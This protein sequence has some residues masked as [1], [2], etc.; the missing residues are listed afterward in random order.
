MICNIQSSMKDKKNK[1]IDGKKDLEK[2]ECILENEEKQNKRI[3]KL[4]YSVYRNQLVMQTI[5]R[6]ISSY[7][8][9]NILE[10]VSNEMTIYSRN[11]PCIDLK[12][13]GGKKIHE[14][15][16]EDCHGQIFAQ[17]NGI[18]KDFNLI[19]DN[20]SLMIES[21]EFFNFIAHFKR[22][23]KFISLH[24]NK[25]YE[26]LSSMSSLYQELFTLLPKNIIT[27]SLKF[28][29]ITEFIEEYCLLLITR[30]YIDNLCIHSCQ[31]YPG[32]LDISFKIPK[33]LNL[34][35]H[36]Q[37][38]FTELVSLVKKCSLVQNLVIFVYLHHNEGF[39]ESNW[40]SLLIECRKVAEIKFTI[41][42]ICDCHCENCYYYIS[43]PSFI[44]KNGSKLMK[45]KEGEKFKLEYLRE[46]N[47][48]HNI[49]C[50]I[51][52]S[53]FSYLDRRCFV[54]PESIVTLG[55]NTQDIICL[56]TSQISYIF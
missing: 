38:T 50:N 2:I 4:A 18:K 43:L 25:R 53:N 32:I 45:N 39:I 34:C 36:I 24:F 52:N 27:A 6:N 47:E 23:I 22:N 30:Q 28:T 26:K 7:N 37:N 21:R 15:L 42:A 10:K 5:L 55:V 20:I 12:N 41:Y 3:S 13:L 17:I 16:L 35:I 33:L 8:E 9:R 29:H 44:S 1:M 51:C 14:L 31:F 40:E 56:R 46:I 11:V 54:R 48:N 19:N 49:I